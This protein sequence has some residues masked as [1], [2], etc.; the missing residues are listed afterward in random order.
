M[1]CRMFSNPSDFY[2]LAAGGSP[3]SRLKND[4]GHCQMPLGVKIAPTENHYP[5][6][7]T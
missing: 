7:S 1:P 5:R 3:W 2:P 4:S 6:Q